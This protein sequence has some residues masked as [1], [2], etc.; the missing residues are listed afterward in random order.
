MNI[1]K[2][3]LSLLLTAPALS[4]AEPTP[5][6]WHPGHYVFVAHGAVTPEV[7]TLP[8]FRGVQKIYSWREFEPEE[9]R[10]DF[11]A[12][13]TD[14]ALARKHGRQLVMQFTHK[15]FVK[16]ERSV[17]DYLTGPEYGGGVYVTVKGALNPVLWNRRVAARLDAVIEA[18]GR[19]FDRDPNLEAVNLPETAPNAYLDKTP[20]AGVEPYTEQVYFEALKR[21]MTTLRRAFPG[22]VVIQYTNFPPKLLVALTDYE[23]EIGVGMGGPDVYPRADA[24]SDPERGVY[25]LYAKLAGTVPMGAAVQQENYATAY[26]KRSALGRGQTTSNGLP[27]VITPEDEIPIPVREHLRLAQEKLKL[28]YLF[29][30]NYPKKGFEN[31]KKLLAEPDLV[32]DP[33]GGLETRLPPKAFLP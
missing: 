22:T 11:S 32:D 14:L 3:V 1:P 18:L 26:K 21:Q 13:R 15:S 30:A 20:Q 7:L 2:L 17:P 33:A 9:G 10:Y 4:T 31:V 29:W 28:N 25:R 16:G 27:I 19:E 24:V 6:K 8:H 12:L 23:K 5:V